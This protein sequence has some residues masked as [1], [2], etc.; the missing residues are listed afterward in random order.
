MKQFVDARPADGIAE[1]IAMFGDHRLARKWL[2]APTDKLG[3]NPPID[4]L[5]TG[6]LANVVAAARLALGEA[7][8][9]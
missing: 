7:P 8:D 1:L 9:V 5:L 3:G 2:M 4:T 6:K